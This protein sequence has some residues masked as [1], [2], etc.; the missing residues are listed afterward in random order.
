MGCLISQ[1]WASCHKVWELLERDTE[2]ARRWA[3]GLLVLNSDPIHEDRHQEEGGDIWG[4]TKSRP[5]PGVGGE[6]ER[7]QEGEWG[8][9]DTPQSGNEKGSALE[10]L[11][12]EDRAGL[13]AKA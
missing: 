4:F 5:L 11:G 10:R 2:R 8:V 13:E 7:K 12:P 9:A 1:L 3:Y 6:E